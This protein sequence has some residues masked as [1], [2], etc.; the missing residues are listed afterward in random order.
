MPGVLIGAPLVAGAV[1]AMAIG[2]ARTEARAAW[3]GSCALLAFVALDSASDL[4]RRLQAWTGVDWERLYLPILAAGAL[5]WLL[6]LRS[7]RSRA[8]VAALI[9]GS[10]CWLLAEAVWI[11]AWRGHVAPGEGGGM[12]DEGL[13]LAGAVLIGIGLAAE[14]IALRGKEEPGPTAR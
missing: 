4:D 3:L 5:A 7:M 8:A 2:A 6:A 11:A 13:E 12:L 14:R 9:A 10:L 1:L